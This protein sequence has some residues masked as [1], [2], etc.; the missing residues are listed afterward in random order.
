MDAEFRIETAMPRFLV[1]WLCSGHG[2]RVVDF[3]SIRNL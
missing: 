3:L 1:R 2:I